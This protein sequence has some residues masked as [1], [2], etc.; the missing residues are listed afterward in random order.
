MCCDP[1]DYSNIWRAFVL[2]FIQLSGLN[3]K[4]I[5]TG[6]LHS[7]LKEAGAGEIHSSWQ[8]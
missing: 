4:Q 8:H 7:A 3:A 2:G 1:S 5:K 6:A